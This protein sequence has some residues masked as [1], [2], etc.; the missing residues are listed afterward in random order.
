MQAWDGYTRYD[1][2]WLIVDGEPG[3]AQALH[4]MIG[5]DQPATLADSGRDARAALS[6]HERWRGFVIDVLLGNES[7]I[8]VL[9][10]ARERHPCVPAV[11]VTGG[12]ERDV[13]KR[14]FSLGAGLMCKPIEPEDLVVFTNRCLAAERLGPSTLA[15]V[16]ALARQHALSRREAELLVHVVSGESRIEAQH[17]MRISKNTLKTHTRSLLRKLD[18]SD[19]S[20]LTIHVLRTALDTSPPPGPTTS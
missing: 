1:R 15:L 7:G 4:R 13:I 14:A 12:L 16:E 10:F 20:E 8:D 11:M 17:N 18:A 6:G 3:C 5:L 9:S 19:L 2:R